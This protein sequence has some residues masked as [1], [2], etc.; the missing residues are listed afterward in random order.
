MSHHKHM[1]GNHSITTLGGDDP[2][3]IASFLG[4]LF[5]PRLYDTL[6]SSPLKRPKSA[7]L[8]SRA[9]SL[10]CILLA[11]LRIL[12]PT[13]SWSLQPKL[14]LACTLPTSLLLVSENK[15]QHSTSHVSKFSTW[16]LSSMHFRK[17]LDCLCPPVL[18]SKQ[19]LGG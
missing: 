10:L 7:L 8:K 1:E 12:K 3:I 18:S 13:I 14:P 11:A 4:S 16:K 17:Y 6:P 2:L 19:L 5:P 9:V 15:V